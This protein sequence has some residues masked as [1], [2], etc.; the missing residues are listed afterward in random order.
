MIN[1]NRVFAMVYRYGIIMRHNLDRITDLFYWPAMDLFIWG[2]TGLYFAGTNKGNP[3]F[4]D[5]ILIGL[6]FWI[7]V[8]RAQYEINVN[9]L[10]E[11]W[12]K[13]IVNIFVSPL[14]VGEWITSF[15]LYGAIKTLISLSFSAFLAFLL[16]KFNVFHFG[17]AILPFVASLLLT[18]W[19]IGF[20]IAAFLIRYGEKIQTMAWTGVY[21]ISPFS[22]VFYPQSILP[23]WAQKVSLFIPSSYV[24]EGLREMIFTG[25]FSYDKLI[26]SFLLNIVYLILAIWF[27]VYMFNKSKKLGLSRLI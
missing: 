25:R 18:G 6:I 22:A 23:E 12:D 16:Y 10:S 1:F 8:W 7:V 5:V 15:V 20:F 19:A 14:T 9:L 2:L 3:H 11:L 4:I 26:I 17:F 21:L 13:N 27:F 24:F